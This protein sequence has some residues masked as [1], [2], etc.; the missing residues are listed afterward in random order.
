MGIFKRRPLC[1]FCLIF[2]MVSVLAD[3]INEKLFDLFSDTVL[4]LNGDSAELIEDY[5]EE[6]KEIVKK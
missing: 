4:L 1:L 2:L 3:G 6:L 5:T